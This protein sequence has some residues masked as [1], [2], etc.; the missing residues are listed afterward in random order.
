[1]EAHLPAPGRNGLLQSLAH[2]KRDPPRELPPP[3][4]SIV[5]LPLHDLRADTAL[6][7]IADGIRARR[8]SDPSR[9]T[10]QEGNRRGGPDP[11]LP[12]RAACRKPLSFMTWRVTGLSGAAL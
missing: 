8:H 1:M 5:I 11:L 9:S 4:L 12:S 6:A 2:R 7:G 10:R 3:E